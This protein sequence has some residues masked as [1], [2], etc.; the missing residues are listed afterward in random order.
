LIDHLVRRG[1]ETGHADGTPPVA[2]EPSGS[3]VDERHIPRAIWFAFVGVGAAFLAYQAWWDAPW[4]GVD[5]KAYLAHEYGGGGHFLYSPAFA[6]LV[7]PFSLVPFPLAVATWRIATLGALALA[8]RGTVFGW[9]VFL[10]PG[11]WMGDLVSCN[12]TGFATAAMIAVIRWPTVRSVALYALMIALIPKPTFLPV[13]AWGAYAVPAARKWIILAG[14]FGIAMLLWPGYLWSVLTDN[15]FMNA[16]FHW[17][18]PW[19]FIAA[20]ALTI[21]GLRWSQALGPAAYLATPYVFP[22][23]SVVL[24]ASFVKR[25]R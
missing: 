10:I 19:G 9:A 13:L 14:G 7:S 18:Q 5:L 11:L 25:E 16:S 22:Y 17:P 20:G 12:V 6:A 3:A 2:S 23:S 24:G 4:A 15:E 1:R 21:A 8:V